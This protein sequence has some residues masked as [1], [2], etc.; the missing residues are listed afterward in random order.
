MQSKAA[1]TF[2]TPLEDPPAASLGYEIDELV[3]CCP[4]LM[5][6]VLVAGGFPGSSSGVVLAGLSSFV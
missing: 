1:R 5:A 6:F 4:S 2:A 3:R